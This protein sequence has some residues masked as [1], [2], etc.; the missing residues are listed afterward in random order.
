MNYNLLIKWVILPIILLWLFVITSC[1]PFQNTTNIIPRE[2]KFLRDTLQT[3]T[4][5]S[6]IDLALVLDGWPGK[7]GIPSIDNPKFLDIS[8]AQKSMRYLSDSK[9]GIVIEWQ[10]EARF[11]PFD[12]LVWHEI[13]NDIIDE[14]PVAITFCPLCWSSIV[15]ERKLDGE[16]IEFWVSGKLYESNMLM[17]DKTTETL[18][19]QS[20]W[21]A[22]VGNLLGKKLTHYPFQLMDFWDFRNTYPQGVVLS[23]KTWFWR[24]YGSVPYG[25]YDT[26]FA[27][28]FPV[29]FE[30]TLFHIKEIF[31]I[32]P[33]AWESY[34]FHFRDI[35]NTWSAYIWDVI[36]TH[37]NGKTVAQDR[38]GNMLPWYFEMWF[39]WRTH[40]KNSQNYWSIKDQ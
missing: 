5:L 29:S 17:Y 14:I 2:Q 10:W 38:S 31:Y 33:Y 12:I 35:K 36:L 30:D 1:T 6:S 20:L 13:V 18:W 28:Y 32:V 27:T 15:F 23:D 7:D 40:N 24:R 4:A 25:D 34:A 37:K 22:L 9:E 16:I 39:S 11:Y 26:S 21:E 8:Q 19:S 3:N